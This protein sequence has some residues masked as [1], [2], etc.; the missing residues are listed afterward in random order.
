MKWSDA[1]DWQTNTTDLTETYSETSTRYALGG[2]TA[3]S[4]G[5]KCVIAKGC[6]HYER[7]IAVIE[8]S[9]SEVDPQQEPI[10]SSKRSQAGNVSKLREAIPGG[11]SIGDLAEE[12]GVKRV[13]LHD[14]L[15]KRSGNIWVQTVK[16]PRLNICE[17]PRLLPDRTIRALRQKA[18]VNR[19]Y[20][21][22]QNK[23]HYLLSRM[24]FCGV[25]RKALTG[26]ESE[27]VLTYRH[28]TH[29]KHN[30]LGGTVRAKSE[31]IHQL[32]W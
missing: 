3:S 22:G 21:H 31:L 11:E 25:C 28:P 2:T 10:A 19:T 5:T 20:T 14:A 4:N 12:Y 17:I 9:S 7:L 1:P 8:A 30:C 27:G 24:V 6:R 15:M 26:Q 13:N 29:T 16:S 18:E 32:C 23:H